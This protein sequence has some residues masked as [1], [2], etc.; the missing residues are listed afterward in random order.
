[1]TLAEFSVTA[2]RAM[3]TAQTT[4]RV[5]RPAMCPG[6]VEGPLTTDSVE[7]VG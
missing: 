1:M 2:P 4:I 7:K 6:K 5:V 3:L